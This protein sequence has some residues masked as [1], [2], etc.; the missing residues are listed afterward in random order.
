MFHFSIG[1]HRGFRH[2]HSGRF[3][4]LFHHGRH[5]QDD[6]ARVN[7]SDPSASADHP[8]NGAAADRT[9]R[10]FTCVGKSCRNNQ[11]G[12]ALLDALRREIA[13]SGP[14]AA[15]IDV[16]SCG[17]LDQC[18]KGPV[19][20]ACQGTAAQSSH[21]PRDILNDPIHRPLATFFH[22]TP[23]EARRIVDAVMKK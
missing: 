14:E 6:N 4:R 18:D 13:L 7:P 1:R 9:I 21:P 15:S 3:D 16:A 20:V 12:R 10:L 22:V 2:R 11:G 23:E 19:V 5:H 17:C 8:S